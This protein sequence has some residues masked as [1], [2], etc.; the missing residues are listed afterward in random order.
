MVS[1]PPGRCATARRLSETPFTN[2]GIADQ[3]LPRGGRYAMLRAREDGMKIALTGG[4]GFIA[5]QIADAYLAAGHEVI[6]IDDLSTGKR[7]NVPSAA[8]FFHADIRSPE[9]AEIFSSERPQVLS[10]HAAQLDVRRSVADPALR[11]RREHAR[12][13]EPARGGAQGRN[14]ARAVRVVGRCGVRRA[15]G[16]P[17][18]GVASAPS[19]LAVRDHQVDRR[20]LSRLLSRRARHPV[21]RAALLQRVRTASGPARRGR[22]WWRSSPSGCSRARPRRSTATASRRATTS[23]SATS[24]APT[25]RHSNPTSSAP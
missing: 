15:A 14:R 19:D 8:K 10:H 9:V 5:S 4:A 17:C 2:G 25:S 20:A 24:C 1:R 21:R 16:I 22:A 13:P 6:V 23:S 7:T 12:H 3:V 11:R 18:A